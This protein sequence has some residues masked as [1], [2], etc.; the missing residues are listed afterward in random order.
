MVGADVDQRK[1]SRTAIA[2]AVVMSYR[3]NQRWLVTTRNVSLGGVL[4]EPG[5]YPPPRPGETV[6][7]SM[8][9]KS[10]GAAKREM[11]AR[12]ARSGQD[13]VALVFGD[14]DMEEFEFIQDL[15]G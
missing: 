14:V 3:G 12:V 2:L 6:T 5:Q 15:M 11:Q 7:L 1:Q 4:I 10:V 13:G 8:P 9:G